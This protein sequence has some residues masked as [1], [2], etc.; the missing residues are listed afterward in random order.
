M[1][2]TDLS[3]QKMAQSKYEGELFFG[4][5]EEAGDILSGRH[6]YA[7]V[8]LLLSVKTADKFA[9]FRRI[10]PS[11]TVM[12]LLPRD[13]A[14]NLFG[15]SDEIS[16]VVAYGEGYAVRA[17][18]YFASVR[19]LPC[20]LFAFSAAA[21]ELAAITDSR[22]HIAVGGEEAEYPASPA[23]YL[24]ADT[25]L[26]DKTSFAEAYAD[27]AMRRAVLFELRFDGIILQTA[28]DRALYETVS[29]A[30]S[31]CGEMPFAALEKRSLF[32]A[33]LLFSLCRARGF[34]RGE[35]ETLAESYRRLGGGPVSAFYA[36]DKLSKV[37]NV[38]F[39]CG[40]YRKYYTPPYH[41]RI[42]RAAGL[43][44]KSEEEISAKQTVPPVEKTALYAE[45]TEGVR[46]Q[47]LSESRE[48]LRRAAQAGEELQAYRERFPVENRLLNA[49]LKYL[50]EGCPHYGIT[51][52]MRDFGLFDF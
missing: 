23:A 25:A 18:R 13:G 45:I 34:P 12:V 52:L 39:T 9:F 51:A 28:Y 21:E 47:F 4:N 37:Y 29:D 46:A 3:L 43:Y 10:F 16:L 26:L 41:A 7:G 2:L 17:A 32:C 22:V 27:A 15:L 33:A 20:A 8:L 49:A 1:R 48:L 35:A 44:G 31:V 36:L 6:P 24:F 14:E 38:F 11:A 30:V 42:R 40:K 5:A 50:P 19:A